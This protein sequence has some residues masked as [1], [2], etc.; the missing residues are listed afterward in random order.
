MRTLSGILGAVCRSAIASAFTVAIVV[1]GAP[2]L[3]AQPSNPST[4]RRATVTVTIE[5]DRYYSGVYTASGMA[6]ICGKWTMSFPDRENGFTVEFPDDEPDLKVR[7]L[8]FDAKALPGG[9]STA[10]FYLAV[11]VR[12][13]QSGAPPLYVVRANEPQYNEPGN[14]TQSTDKGVTT[15]NVTGTAALGVTVRAKVTCDPKT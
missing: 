10:S 7:S 12:V 2:S 14:A 9:G 8:S 5:N 4:L 1:A 15:L 11:G 13:G 3:G 6:R